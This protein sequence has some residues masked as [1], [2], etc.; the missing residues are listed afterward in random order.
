MELN[1]IDSNMFRITPR[2]PVLVSKGK[3]WR[4][5]W[6]NGLPLDKWLYDHS[7]VPDGARDP[8]FYTLPL[9]ID[10]VISCSQ[11]KTC[12]KFIIKESSN[13]H[14]RRRKRKRKVKHF[15]S[16]TKRIVKE[17][18]SKKKRRRDTHRVQVLF[19]TEEDTCH[20]IQ[21]DCCGI[22]MYPQNDVNR[23][24]CATCYNLEVCKCCGFYGDTP[25]RVC[26]IDDL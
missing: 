1:F 6:L 16:K 25:C 12:A 19:D 17:L 24:I 7:P 15:V 8:L 21:C 9:P 22:D 18:R 20:T 23:P 26:R 3:T 2:G 13:R 14:P 4:D 10:E 5:I 11:S